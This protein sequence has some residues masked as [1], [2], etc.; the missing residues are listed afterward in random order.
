MI[1]KTPL[2][3][4]LVGGGSDLSYFYK[5]HNG[6]SLGFPIKFYNYIYISNL[7]SKL[8]KF[9]SD[10]EN[11]E[12]NDHNTIKNDILRNTIA[13]FK[14][15]SKKIFVFS[16][17]PYGTGLG[18][19]SAMSVGLIKAIS[20]IKNLGLNDNEIANEAYKIEKKAS[21][22]TIGKQDHYM[23]S[24]GGINLFSYKKDESTKIQKIKITNLE[25]SNIEKHLIL[26]RVGGIRNASEILHDQKNNLIHNKNKFENMKLLVNF[27][28]LVKNS[29]KTGN[30]KELGELISE[31]WELKKTFSKYISGPEIEKLYQYLKSNGIYGGKLLGAGQ[32]GFFLVICNSK[33]RKKIVNDL[34]KN[35]IVNIN[36]D[37]KGSRIILDKV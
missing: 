14:V 13:K 1:I 36:L 9:V 31:T 15:N 7:D 18:S 33:V 26:I 22:S 19:S 28:P 16:D 4:S 32:S 5:K 2:R 3:L 29:I 34:P 35:K 10:K 11:I 23:S 12:T 17:L 37:K 27:V 20:H 25:I 24:Y 21:G 30:F 6:S 8:I